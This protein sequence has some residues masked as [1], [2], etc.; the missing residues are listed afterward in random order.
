VLLT[1]V[2][3]SLADVFRRNPRSA[4]SCV[5]AAPSLQTGGRDGK[6]TGPLMGN[7]ASVGLAS[8]RR[9]R[10]KPESSV[11]DSRAPTMARL[12]FASH[13]THCRFRR[14]QW[15]RERASP[16]SGCRGFESCRITRPRHSS[17]DCRAFGHVGRDP[18]LR[19]SVW[20]VRVQPEGTLSVSPLPSIGQGTSDFQIRRYG[21][22][23][24]PWR[25]L[26]HACL[27]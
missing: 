11:E 3:R 12:Q 15:I 21:G 9:E 18:S 22:S 16:K 5:P 23:N 27:R 19:R 1:R 13:G 14:F 24:S 10:R 4:A 2:G 26:A 25:T 20:L 7:A 17:R 6:T 8:S